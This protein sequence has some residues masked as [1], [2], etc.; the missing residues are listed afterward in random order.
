MALREIN[1]IAPEI[2]ARIYRW[3]HLSLWAACLIF[4][5][6]IISGYYLYETRIVLATKGALTRLKETQT[7]RGLKIEEIK[8]VQKELDNLSQQQAVLE[9]IRKN[10]SYS[11]ILVSLADL[12]NEFTWLTQLTIDNEKDKDGSAGL[13]L[14]GSSFSNEELGAFLNRLS[15]E[16]MCKSVVLK[17]SRESE[18]AQLTA[19]G[20]TAGSLIQFQIE[21]H[22][23]KGA[24]K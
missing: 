23:L 9:S 4:L 11:L 18:K 12:M 7:S 24:L 13:L 2:L 3:R 21:C 5:L 1:L 19:G 6:A 14:T 20:G 16:S 8:Q 15:N 10:Q 22:I 17:Y